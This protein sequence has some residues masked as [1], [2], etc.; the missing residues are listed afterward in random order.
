MD[1][2]D[3]APTG[4]PGKLEDGSSTWTWIAG[5]LCFVFVLALL[6]AMSGGDQTQMALRPARIRSDDNASDHATRSVA[7]AR[8]QWCCVDPA[9]PGA[10][11]G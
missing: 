7:A 2:Q 8:L 3:L 1:H 9:G 10:D 5:G 4:L 6:F 11:L